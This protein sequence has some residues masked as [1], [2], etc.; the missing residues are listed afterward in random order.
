[1]KQKKY[2]IVIMHIEHIALYSSYHIT[3]QTYNKN[4]CYYSTDQL[5][6]HF[7]NRLTNNKLE[8]YCIEIELLI[9]DMAYIFIDTLLIRIRIY[10]CRTILQLTTHKEYDE[11]RTC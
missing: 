5:L 8:F 1:M 10:S 11:Q 9:F 4:L 7:T 2:S 6:S 3:I